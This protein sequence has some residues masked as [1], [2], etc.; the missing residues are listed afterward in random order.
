M[1]ISVI[2]VVFNNV[3]LIEKTIQSVLNQS[4]VE[5][6]YIIVDGASTDGTLDVIKK[7]ADRIAG[8]ISEPDRGIYDAMNKGIKMCTGDYI[9]F[10]NSGDW[11]ENGAISL[12][13]NYMKKYNKDIFYGKVNKY[14][15]EKKMGY[16]G[17]TSEMQTDMEELHLKN[18]FCHQGMFIR[19]SCFEQ[20]GLYNIQ[21]QA[22]GDYDWNLRA[23]NAGM[24]FYMIKECVANYLEGGFSSFY[25]SGKEYYEIA[26]N[27]LN[28]REDFIPYIQQKSVFYSHRDAMY[29]VLKEK[30]ETLYEI[31]PQTECYYI[32]GVGQDGLVVYEMLQRLN[33]K[34]VGFVDK[35]PNADD[36]MGVPIYCSR[37]D[38]ILQVLNKENGKIIIGTFN[39]E[40]EITSDIKKLQIAEEKYISLREILDFVDSISRKRL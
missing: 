38:Q 9:A 37:D 24:S 28:G 14:V 35:A 12:M 23:Y 36:Y 22:L 16:M 30:P 5:L 32:W 13:V 27:G 31:L 29:C 20:I 7:Y 2:T 25:N 4:C 11:Y 3:D 34:V 40:R 15:G 19:R 8:F 17:T 39:F 33:L 18:V 6:E 1:K 10:M 21:Y 26:M